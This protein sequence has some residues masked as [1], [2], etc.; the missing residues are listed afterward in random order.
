LGQTRRF[1]TP[2]DLPGP[3]CPISDPD[4]LV[5]LSKEAGHPLG[6]NLGNCI[7]SLHQEAGLQ[8]TAVLEEFHG[9]DDQAWEAVIREGYAPMHAR[10]MTGL[11]SA[12][13]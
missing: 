8:P 4:L 7:S 10:L 6:T 9:R 5:V 3:G 11:A 1:G 2:Q 13:G 12:A